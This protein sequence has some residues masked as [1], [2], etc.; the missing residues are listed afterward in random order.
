MML[1]NLF[2]TTNGDFQ[3]ATVVSVE[4]GASPAVS[5]GASSDAPLPGA[6]YSYDIAIRLGG[7]VYQAAYQSSFEDISPV[8]AA[9]QS[10]QATR[11]GNVLYVTLP[12]KLTVP[13]AIEGRSA[14]KG[15]SGNTFTN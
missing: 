3:P 4:Q 10:V 6:S 8:F 13:M 5:A 2:A 11:K 14:V 7:V 12:G 9:N 1:A 15:A